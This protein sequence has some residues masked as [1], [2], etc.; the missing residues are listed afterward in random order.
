MRILP[1]LIA[2][3]REDNP[4][5]LRNAAE[6]VRRAGISEL[7]PY[8]HA[9]EAKP[10]PAKT[11]LTWSPR[12]AA[13]QRQAIAWSQSL[14]GSAR[15]ACSHLH[16]GGWHRWPGR[17]QAGRFSSGSG[18]SRQRCRSH[19]QTG[20]RTP[21]NRRRAEGERWCWRCRCADAKSPPPGIERRAKE[22]HE[23]TD[24]VLRM[25]TDQW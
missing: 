12:G 10:L 16:R 15:R 18:G 4:A 25:N 3:S 24:R 19:R 13:V 1:S 20:G 21:Q 14:A 2:P 9:S 7:E 22:A 11:L 23:T 5:D 17:S 6:I 8:Q